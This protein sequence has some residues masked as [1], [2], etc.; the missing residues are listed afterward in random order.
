MG[1]NGAHYKLV[2]STALIL[3]LYMIKVGAPLR[4]RKNIWMVCI[5]QGPM[6]TIKSLVVG[7]IHRNIVHR[8][9]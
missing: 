2:E 7:F 6:E 3:G 1:N 8:S 9:S 5:A 4:L